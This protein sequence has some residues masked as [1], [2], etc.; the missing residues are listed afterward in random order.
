MDLHLM[1]EWQRLYEEHESQLDRLYE[2]VLEGRLE[3]LR[4]FAQQ[5]PQL[6]EL[7]RYGSAGDIGLLHMA[8]SEGQAEVCQLL[9]ELGLEVDRP[10]EVC[11]QETA[12][13][14]AASEGSLPTCTVLLDAGASANGLP[15]S[16]CPP[17]YAAALAGHDQVVALLLARG[18]AVNQLH[19]RFNNTALDAART[20]GHPAVAG[21]LQANGAQSILDIDVQ[22]VDGPGQAIATF[23]H[24]SAGWV[25]P[26]LFGPPSADP[27]FSLHISLL[28][29]GRYKLLFT[30]GLYRTTPMTELFVCLPEDWALPQ[31]GLA[32]Q[33]A[34]CFPVQLLARL[35][36]QSLEHQALS[37]GMLV[38]RDDP[39]YADLAW[40][41][42]VDA[43]LVVDKPWDPAS[44][45]EEIADDDGVELLLLVPVKFT[46][47]ARP[48][49]EALDAL[50]ARKRKA[51]WKVLALKSPA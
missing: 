15:L 32:Q 34:W 18:A 8:A 29:K 27:R 39:G 10:V 51:S 1:T 28:T 11:G 2:D 38:L 14:L 17:L 13:G 43:M 19:R 35:A 31:H 25:L 50:V 4:A 44:A 21:L 36:R 20:W 3:R 26:A 6:L 42:S 41:D 33:P 16:I 45:A 37:E 24:N 7:P 46:A 47:K 30:I 23:V 40:P 9:L 5:Y 49:G 12:L 22:D 48:T